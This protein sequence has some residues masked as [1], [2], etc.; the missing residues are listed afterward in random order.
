MDARCDICGCLTE[1]QSLTDFE[2]AGEQFKVCSYCKKNLETVAANPEENSELAVNIFTMDNRHR[3]ERAKRAL[4]R[5]FGS[6]GVS[7]NPKTETNVPSVAA[8]VQGDDVRALIG[9]VEKLE[10]ELDRFKRRYYLSKALGITIPILLIVVVFIVM[11]SSGAIDNLK[12]YY[13]TI[14]EYAN[15]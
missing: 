7:G 15:M 9:R 3:S 14:L 2:M 1:E 10:K 8:P 11:V 12:N 5:Y 6:L 13:N 4:G